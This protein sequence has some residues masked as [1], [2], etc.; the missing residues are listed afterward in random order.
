MRKITTT[1]GYDFDVLEN[2]NVLHKGINQDRA[3]KVIIT[4]DTIVLRTQADF[5]AYQANIQEL[6]DFATYPA[7]LTNEN[8]IVTRS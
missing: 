8:Y 5:I 1:T 7:Y 6:G 3:E 4:T 2:T